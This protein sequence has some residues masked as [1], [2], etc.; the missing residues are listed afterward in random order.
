M[1]ANFTGVGGTRQPNNYNDKHLYVKAY[2][3]WLHAHLENL[4][5]R[6]SSI[7]LMSVRHYFFNQIL[8]NRYVFYQAITFH[9]IIYVIDNIKRHILEIKINEK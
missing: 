7:Y 9:C 3:Q 1:H 2:I 6:R 8:Q 4:Q 5:T